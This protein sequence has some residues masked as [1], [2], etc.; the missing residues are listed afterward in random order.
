MQVEPTQSERYIVVGRA[1]DH[2][3]AP[4][5][6]DYTRSEIFIGLTLLSPLKSDSRK[7]EV[8]SINH[9]RYGGL[10]AFLA[11]R[12]SYHPTINYYTHLNEMVKNL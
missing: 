8:T 9:V 12:N 1:I 7:T 4:P 6:H 3:S 10:P 11:H 5:H 2:H